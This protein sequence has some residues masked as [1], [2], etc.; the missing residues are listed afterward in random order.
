MAWPNLNRRV[1]RVGLDV[2]LNTGLALIDGSHPAAL[3]EYI[4]VLRGAVLGSERGAQ[5]A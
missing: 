1:G 2:G 5:L 3:H 4:A